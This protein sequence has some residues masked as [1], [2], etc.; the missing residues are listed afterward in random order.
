MNSHTS[1]QTNLAARVGD[2]VYV[3]IIMKAA[4]YWAAHRPGN[5][6]RISND[7]NRIS[8]R[9]DGFDRVRTFSREKV[10]LT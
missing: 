6:T 3:R 2:S 1:D 7:G 5:I 9:L 10:T 4:S 8:V